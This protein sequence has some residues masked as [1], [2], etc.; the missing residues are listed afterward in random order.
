M[1]NILTESGMFSII[2]DV[3]S[4]VLSEEELKEMHLEGL[5]LL[6]HEKIRKM[7][8]LHKYDRRMLLYLTD[9][10]KGI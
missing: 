6:L 10:I 2:T 3:D 8:Y 1:K 5:I 7:D 4:N 9:M